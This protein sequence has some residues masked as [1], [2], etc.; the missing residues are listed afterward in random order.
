MKLELVCLDRE[1][2]NECQEKWIPIKQLLK[3]YDENCCITEHI[4]IHS[5]EIANKALNTKIDTLPSVL[6]YYNYSHEYLNMSEHSRMHSV[7]KLDADDIITTCQNYYKDKLINDSNSILNSK[8]Q[9][10]L[11]CLKL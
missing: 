2:Y 5:I 8:L 1:Q 3:K 7:H 6:I 9:Y 4:N 10:L 11:N